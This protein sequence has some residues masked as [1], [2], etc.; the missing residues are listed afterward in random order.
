MC[1]EN[2]FG[3]GTIFAKIARKVP[4]FFVHRQHVSAQIALLNGD[5]LAQLTLECL[6][7]VVHGVDVNFE[8]TLLLGAKFAN[9]TSV[10]LFPIHIVPNRL[11]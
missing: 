10:Q 9:R 8:Q 5:K 3:S 2:A 4:R 1:L 6:H 7:F 11:F